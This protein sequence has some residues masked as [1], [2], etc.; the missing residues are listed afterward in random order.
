[1][2]AVRR[3]LRT[4]DGSVALYFA[5]VAM[6]AFAMLGLVVDGGQALASRERAA[7][8]AAQA[9]RAAADA[10]SLDAVHGQPASMQ[11]DPASAQA[12]ADRLVTAASG[13]LDSLTVDGGRVTVTV[14]VHRKTAVLSAFGLTDI[15]QTASGSATYLYGGTTAYGGG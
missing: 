8:L 7:D 10:L 1:M 12:A 6:A 4:E 14:T 11:V 13:Q 3:C 5:I 2:P 15:S 9:A